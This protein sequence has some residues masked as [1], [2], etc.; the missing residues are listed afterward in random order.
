MIRVTLK[1]LSYFAAAADAGSL[2]RAAKALRVSQP[3]ISAALTVLENTLEVDLFLRHHAQGVSLTPTGRQLLGTA[4]AILAGAEDLESLAR[5]ASR[6]PAGLLRVGCYPTLAAVLMPAIIGHLGHRYPMIRVQMI[7]GTEDELLP[8][9]ERGNIEQALL[10]GEKLPDTVRRIVI[11]RCDPYILLPKAHPLAQKKSVS[12]RAL[13]NEPFILMDT[14]AGREYFLAILKDAGISPQIAHRSPSFEVVRGLVGQGLGFSLLVT[15]PTFHI[16][17]DG[18]ELAYLAIKESPS[19]A[20]IC[21]VRMPS[22]RTTRLG[23]IF[24][25]ACLSSRRRRAPDSPKTPLKSG[26]RSNR[27][28]G[29]LEGIKSKLR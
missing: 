27:A 12:L 20:M 23:A 1:Q 15:R 8:A 5:T 6:E 18:H 2:A 26:S 17:Y 24:Q 14:P 3:S 16:T 28:Q 11:E 19:P 13:E 10:F 29:A 22:A 4:R 25:E 21:L 7:E 9:L